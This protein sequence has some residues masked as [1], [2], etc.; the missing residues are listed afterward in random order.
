MGCKVSG[1]RGVSSPVVEDSSERETREK[2]S[3]TR[4]TGSTGFSRRR[5]P[6]GVTSFGSG[7]GRGGPLEGA[8]GPSSLPIVS[9]TKND[10]QSENRFYNMGPRLTQKV[11]F[12]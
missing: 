8:G 7:C 2:T 3:K 10:T 12:V 9:T 5:I 4:E 1:L 11:S 6:L